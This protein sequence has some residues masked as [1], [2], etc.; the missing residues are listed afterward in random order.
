[1]LSTRD[2]ATL[3]EVRA[4]LAMP[5]SPQR[6]EVWSAAGERVFELVDSARDTTGIRAFPDIAPPESPGISELAESDGFAYFTL[7]S[8][9]RD[10]N[11]RA[12]GYL[13][14]FGQV[15]ISPPTILQELLGSGAELRLGTPGTDRW[16][17]FG[18]F[19]GRPPAPVRRGFTGEMRG[20]DGS[21][22]VGA[23]AAIDG[24]PWHVWMGYPRALVLEPARDYLKRTGLL[25]GALLLLFTGAGAVFASRLTRPLLNV[26]SVAERIA[27]GDL[28]QRAEARG[29]DEVARLATAFNT[30]TDRLTR[31]H[32][33]LK[34][35]HHLTNFALATARIGVW[36]VNL[37][38]GE[39][40]CSDS[41]ARVYDIPVESLPTNVE[42][43]AALVHPD[44]RQW[45]EELIAG[46]ITSG[47]V[48][49]LRFRTAHGEKRTRWIE[50][51]GRV[52]KDAS[53]RPFSVFGVS[54]DVTER[55]RLE[56]Q[57]RQAQK[58][59]AV[60]QLAGGV[61]HDF[62]NLL[63]AIVGHA[64]MLLNTVPEGAE[65]REDVIGILQAAENAAGLTRQLLL[66]SRAKTGEPEVI[67]VNPVVRRTEKLL[68]RLIGARIQIVLDLAEDVGAVR[69]EPGHIEQILINLVVNARDAMPTGGTVV[70]RT[71]S[72][73]VEAPMSPAG[74]QHAR[75]RWAM[76]EV[77]DTGVGMSEDTISHI[78]DPF[79]TTKPEGQGTG[80]GLSTVFGIAQKAD[81]FVS[82]SSRLGEGATFRVYLPPAAEMPAERAAPARPAER[83][84]REKIL[85]VE[86]NPAVRPVVTSMLQRIGYEVVAASN[87]EEALLQ[88]ATTGTRPDL[89]VT[90]VD[91]PGISGP[92]LVREVKTQHADVPVIYTSGYEPDELRHFG[93]SLNDGI[94]VTKPY[95]PGLLAEK[96]REALTTTRARP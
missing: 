2:S 91:M 85:I 87:G 52:R 20:E 86:D 64:T 92:E 18:S 51:K 96:V 95:S 31:A 94:F 39:V 34:D 6:V 37:E 89:V 49:D 19:V 50:G 90:D 47:E 27:A 65:A 66:F 8:E 38:A 13:R 43:F 56:A 68:R 62:N 46:R 79:F 28:S 82:V 4:L 83:G 40:R 9:I 69:V 5:S 12:I 70:I 17:D 55:H 16:T 75:K 11:A 84:R 57:L 45:V 44:D 93:L 25:A 29:Q 78:F 30:M 10:R 80:L 72:A 7:V 53:D 71:R 23:S 41:M 35:T 21:R 61:A 54:I 15:T 26:A 63:T 42:E 67:A 76:I 33:S 77:S 24:A 60:G 74:D 81:G 1:M 59:Q 48:F 14:R 58:M 22:W 32:Q 88:L 36:D 73:E 3:E